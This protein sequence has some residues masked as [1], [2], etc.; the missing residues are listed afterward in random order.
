[1]KLLMKPLKNNNGAA[2][3]LMMIVLSVILIGFA[4]LIA[5]INI[6][7]VNK[8]IATTR[9][10]AVADSVAVFAL[11]YD[12]TFS[13]SDVLRMTAL[14]ASYNTTDDRPVVFMPELAGDKIIIRTEVE[15]RFLTSAKPFTSYGTSVVQAVEPGTGTVWIP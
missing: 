14:L 7:Y 4:I 11:N 8:T 9:A 10:D 5:E 6:I 2:M 13:Q 1:M 3:L 12:N 15:G